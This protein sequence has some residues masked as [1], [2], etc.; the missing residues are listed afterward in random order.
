MQAKYGKNL[1]MKSSRRKCILS[2]VTTHFYAEI[3]LDY[4]QYHC[5]QVPGISTVRPL[6]IEC[7]R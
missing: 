2:A 3:C 1:A 4:R 7:R 6:S 5:G